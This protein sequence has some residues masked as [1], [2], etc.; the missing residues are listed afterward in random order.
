MLRIWSSRPT[1]VSDV[2]FFPERDEFRVIS[3]TNSAGRDARFLGR[4]LDLLPVLID[5]G[6]EEDLL[7]LQPMITRDDI[8]QHL[9]VGV[10]DVRRARWCNRSRW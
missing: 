2:E 10:A 8:G 9:L 7:A 4:L 6:E 3:S 1:V 5:A